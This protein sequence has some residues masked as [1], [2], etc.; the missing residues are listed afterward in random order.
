MKRSRPGRDGM[1]SAPPAPAHNAERAHYTSPPIPR[2][3]DPSPKDSELPPKSPLRP[4]QG[5][6]P[7]SPKESSTGIADKAALPL[8][9]P[10]RSA[11]STT[12]SG[13]PTTEKKKSKK[14]TISSHYQDENRNEGDL[15][16]TPTS[17]LRPL[18][19]ARSRTSKA[20]GILRRQEVLLRPPSTSRHHD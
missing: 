6:N 14:S 16:D 3:R 13:M 8:D 17:G 1:D 7:S 2:S 5:R 19:M 9:V 11:K 18:E 20:R 10:K 12:S 15:V 4:L